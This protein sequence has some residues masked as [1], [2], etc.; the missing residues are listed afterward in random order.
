MSAEAPNASFLAIDAGCARIAALGNINGS[1]F[2]PFNNR[3][4]THEARQTKNKASN[5]EQHMLK[6]I[7][8]I[9]G[10]GI[11]GVLIYAAFKPTTFAL[12]RSTVIAADPQRVFALINDLRQFN[13]WNPFAQQDPGDTVHYEA[14]TQGRGAAFSWDGPKAGAG[15]IEVSE[16]VA[17]QRVAMSLEFKKPMN[18]RNEAVFSLNPEQGGTK[19][20][21]RMSGP[22]PYLN[23][24]VTTF[25]DMDKMVG[26]QFEQGLAALKSLAEQP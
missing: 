14:L 4:S 12:E 8:L 10:S 6:L 3:A 17:L 20:T 24:L 11:A 26:S 25:F 19:V 21:W 13:R 2:Q 5:P 23:R 7:L 16:S 1:P 22:M 18:M 9:V 15:R